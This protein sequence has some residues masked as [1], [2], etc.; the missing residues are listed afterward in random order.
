MRGRMFFLLMFVLLLSVAASNAWASL[1]QQREK[2]IKAE[3]A[4]QNNRIQQYQ[5]LL[6]ELEEYPL[7][8][9]LVYENLRRNISLGNEKQ[10]LEFLDDYSDSPLSSMLRQS[11]INYLVRQQQWTT[12]VRDYQPVTSA[13]LQCSYARALLE[14][15]HQAKARQ[16]AERLWQHGR[17]RPRECDPV[18]DDWRNAGG[19]STDLVWTRIELAMNQGQHGLVR[20][21]KRYLPREDHSLA[22]LWINVANDPARTL[23]ID[24]T[25]QKHS[26][27][28]KILAQG[29]NRLIRQDTPKALEDWNNL[30]SRHDLSAFNTA[31][32]EQE[33]AR[34]LAL[35][36]YPQAVSY[37]NSL[38]DETVTSQSRQWHVRS[39]LLAGEWE[40]ALAAWEKLDQNHQQ[41]PRWQ[42]W[43]AR[44]LEEMGL[45]QEASVIYLDLL[46]RQNYFSL[47]SADRIHQPYR[48]EHNPITAYGSN[49][50]EM[51][52][53]P[54]IRRAMEFY[55]L[56][57][58]PDARREWNFAV[59]E[60]NSDQWRA[61]AIVAHDYGWH[62]RAIIA[63]AR[64]AEFDD[65]IIRFPLSFS[66]LI[67][68]YS[69]TRK[70]D[71]TWVFALARQESMFMADVGSPAGA[72]GVM[73]IM[74]ATGRRIAS[75][76][77]E[78]LSNQYALLCPERN[79]RFG[80]YYLSMRL[81]ELQNNPV[82][83]TAAYNAG[84][85]RV[86]SWLPDNGT[87][88][89]DIWVENIPF[90]ET[91]DYIE[92]VFTYKAIYQSRLG[93][94]P[95]RLSSFMP[96]ILGHNIVSAKID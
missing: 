65:L 60:V 30:K 35:R 36:K 10:I 34:F 84:A 68:R 17:S 48:I 44:I 73:Q 7:Y 83:A 5:K 85:H 49:I 90:F 91:R 93:L 82:L 37:F 95:T 33:I 89:A 1:E 13:S 26:V 38:P 12:L 62:D 50:V 14:T 54:A 16:E 74:P 27:A 81:E 2:F 19:L 31:P 56:N 78:S 3:K 96:D 59:S 42:Y 75:M 24:W 53:N 41:E 9:Y 80:T 79:I 67:N 76:L 43:R 6:A 61:A 77:G 28:E 52:H 23:R 51:R 11:W 8:P 20:Y 32:I 55:Y 86:R 69:A 45:R 70:L 15:G 87:I 94:E 46:G 72:L 39:A 57:R 29:M 88:A 58:L 92:K 25:S 66:D 21:L 22:D 71:P 4:L 63:A 18:F 64:A 40:D 47:L